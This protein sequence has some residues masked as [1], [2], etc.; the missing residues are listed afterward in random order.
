MVLCCQWCP[1]SSV[2]GPLLFILHV[3][4]IPD[5]VN[6]K[7]KMFAD[8]IKIYTQI[9]SFSD[10]LSFQNDLDKLCGWSRELLLCF[11]IAKC[12]HLKYGTNASSNGHYMNDEES[13][14][15]LNV[16]SLGKDLG[17]WITSRPDH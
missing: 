10:A 13:N 11:N 14:S 3:N 15:K 5:L 12:K 1:T 6:S 16:V 2:L 8:D 7:I 4:D 17:V 9:R